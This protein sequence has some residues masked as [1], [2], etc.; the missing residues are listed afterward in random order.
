VLGLVTSPLERGLIALRKLGT[1]IQRG[2]EKMHGRAVQ[3][4][5]QVCTAR[6]DAPVPAIVQEKSGEIQNGLDELSIP[7]RS[8]CLFRE[9]IFCP[10]LAAVLETL[11]GVEKKLPTEVFH[12]RTLVELVRGDEDV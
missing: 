9:I 3:K 4:A 8:E 12:L 1:D 11:N 5:T 6:I 2:H 10:I 7:I